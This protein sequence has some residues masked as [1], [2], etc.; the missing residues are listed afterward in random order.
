[1]DV[2]K[3]LEKDHQEVKSIMEKLADSSESAVKTRE[4]LFKQLATELAL[5]AK[6]EETIVYPRLKEFEE[7]Q[8]LVEEGIEE[9]QEAEQLLTEL[10]Q[11]SKDDK[12][13]VAKL[14]ELK[15]AVEHHVQEEENEVFPQARDLLSEDEA[16]ELG[17]TVEQEKKE[18]KKGS[19]GAAKDV[20]D[21]LGL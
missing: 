19:H 3:L 9:H 18:M 14:K 16:T 11:M 8:D 15:Q 13:W 21:R 5:H 12:Q 7:L 10:S 20:F 6:A 4:K 1:M 2:F 17:K